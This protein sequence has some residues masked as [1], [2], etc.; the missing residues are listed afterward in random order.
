MAIRKRSWMMAVTATGLLLLFAV[1]TDAQGQM[2]PPPPQGG[3]EDPSALL[4]G[5]V[6]LQGSTDAVSSQQAAQLLA[7]VEAWRMQMMQ[8]SVAP[9]GAPPQQ[10][11]APIGQPSPGTSLADGIRAILTPAQWQAIVVMNLSASDVMQWMGLSA[12]GNPTP[13]PE[14]SPQGQLPAPPP[15][16]S[17]FG[18]PPPS[19]G[20]RPDSPMVQFADAVIALLTSRIAA[21]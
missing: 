1:A 3:T 13:P 10:G 9:T 4:L 21:S 2:N 20:A 15:A 6:K 18:T 8:P 16:G 17:S 5:I 12:F 19:S 14:G 11:Q 7:L